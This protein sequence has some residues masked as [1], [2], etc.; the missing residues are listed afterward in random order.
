MVT[1]KFAFKEK[2]LKEDGSFSHYV[3]P[4]VYEDE[5]YSRPF[6]Y[7]FYTQEEALEFLQGQIEEETITEEDVQGW[8]LCEIITKPIPNAIAK[9]NGFHERNPLDL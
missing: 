9:F 7:V 6:N 2:F 1:T 5:Y 3:D 8:E 4:Q